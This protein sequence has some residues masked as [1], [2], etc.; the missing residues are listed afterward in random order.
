MKLNVRSCFYLVIIAVWAVTA[1]L[2]VP[3]FS[4]LAAREWSA[5]TLTERRMV[6]F[7]SASMTSL[8][9]TNASPT[10][11]N[12]VRAINVLESGQSDLK[13]RAQEKLTLF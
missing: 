2:F 11:E 1:T 8:C 3:F 10:S 12:I 5:L 4:C 9:L 6:L 7:S 13:A